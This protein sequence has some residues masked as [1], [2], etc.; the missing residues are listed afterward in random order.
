MNRGAYSTQPIVLPGISISRGANLC[1]IG[2]QSILVKHYRGRRGHFLNIFAFWYSV[3]DSFCPVRKAIESQ[4]CAHDLN[5]K[6][7]ICIGVIATYYNVG[8]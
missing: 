2:L 7:S 6:R 5:G 8:D 4:K 3:K 1:H